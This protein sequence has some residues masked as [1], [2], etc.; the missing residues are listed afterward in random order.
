MQLLVPIFH[1]G[2]ETR[3]GNLF[4]FPGTC[5][6]SNDQGKILCL[7]EN[8]Q[9]LLNDLVQGSTMKEFEKGFMVYGYPGQPWVK[10]LVCSKNQ[11]IANASPSTEL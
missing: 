9:A 3:S 2:R 6:I 5:T 1:G 10:Y 11:A 8:S 7:R 4:F